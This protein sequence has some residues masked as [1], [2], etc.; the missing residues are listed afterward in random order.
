VIVAV[1]DEHI[2]RALPGRIDPLELAARAVGIKLS[3]GRERILVDH[4]SEWRAGVLAPPQWWS[5]MF[6]RF[7]AAGQ[8]EWSADGW[9][10]RG[11]PA[12]AIEAYDFEIPAQALDKVA[13]PQPKPM[14]RCRACGRGAH[15]AGEKCSA[16]ALGRVA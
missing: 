11:L 13:R 16:A 2:R 6:T 7:H 1:T 9:R 4:G 10:N 3:A 12:Q 8:L 15:R 14:G 5:V